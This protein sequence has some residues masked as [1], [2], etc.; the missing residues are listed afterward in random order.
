MEPVGLEGAPAMR[1]DNSDE[2]LRTIRNIQSSNQASDIMRMFSAYVGNYGFSHIYLGQLVNPANV[3]AK[4]MLQISTWPQEL[5][6][7]RRERY[8]ILHDPI[9]QAALRSKRPFR[10]DVA[11]KWATRT[12]RKVVDLTMEYGIG[13]GYLFPVHVLG[14]VSGAVSLGG[15]SLDLSPQT[16]SEIELVSLSVYAQLESVLGPFPY[17]EITE[18]SAREAEVIQFAAAGKTNQD[19]GIILGIQPD[20]VKKT[21]QRASIK[22]GTLNRAHTVATAIA[23]NLIF[24]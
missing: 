20:T 19:I 5:L 2:I 13:D 21:L 9:A 16:I 7:R 23:K 8:A 11:M 15:E 18:L 22:L 14:S 1:L 10:W 4:D 12:G 17:Q 3:A 24:P 6:E